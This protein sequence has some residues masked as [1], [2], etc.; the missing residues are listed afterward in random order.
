LSKE[1]KEAYQ[2]YGGINFGVPPPNYDPAE[3]VFHKWV[4]E[5]DGN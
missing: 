1:A 5:V 3:R 2:K 4:K